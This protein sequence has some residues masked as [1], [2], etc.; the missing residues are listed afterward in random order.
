MIRR[1]G[2]KQRLKAAGYRLAPQITTAVMSSR[3]RAHSAAVLKQWGL[4][5]LNQRL[6]AEIGHQVMDG[7]FAGMTLTPS[8][9]QQ[10]VG[11]YL[12][13]T[14]EMELHSWV[15]ECCREPFRQVVDVGSSF[16]YYAVG[17]AR[18]IPSA[19]V[20]AFDT[21]WWARRAVS[22]MA[23]ANGVSNVIVKTRCTPAW[24]SQH[25]QPWSLVVSDC[26]GYERTLF[27]GRGL[28]ALDTATLIV[29]L[30]EESPGELSTMFQERFSRTHAIAQVTG[31]T[32]TPR[33]RDVKGLTTDEV[34]RVSQEVRGPQ[35][36]IYL[37]PITR[38]EASSPARG[39]PADP[40]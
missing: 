7:P 21:D 22:E 5:G 23:A 20:C 36:W 17:L 40:F 24:F 2:W 30:H 35:T 27:F 26:E 14:Y 8:A 32:V 33:M 11:P 6:I 39:Y 13:G 18:R 31:R 12:L 1:L 19:S 3:A 37:R 10:H 15:E 4:S 38:R 28:S 16:G 25:L 9:E 34:D 29:E